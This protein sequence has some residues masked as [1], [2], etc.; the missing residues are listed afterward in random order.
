MTQELRKELRL[1][2]QQP[3][4]PLKI[5]IDGVT[6]LTIHQIQGISPKVVAHLEGAGTTTWSAMSVPVDE[7]NDQWII[8]RNAQHNVARQ[9][10]SLLEE[11]WHIL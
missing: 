6:V 2:H 10:V 9:H 1:H 4:D 11:F 8:V 7:E 5:A 3:L